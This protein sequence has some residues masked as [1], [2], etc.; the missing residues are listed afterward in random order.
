MDV[1]RMEF[2]KNQSNGSRDAVEELACSAKTLTFRAIRSQTYTGCSK[3]VESSSYGVS[4]EF[5][6]LKPRYTRK[7][8]LFPK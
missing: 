7:G 1:Q 3:C 4:G 5:A 2:Q 6:Q 8:V